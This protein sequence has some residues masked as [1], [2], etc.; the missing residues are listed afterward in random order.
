MLVEKKD[1]KELYA[2][3]SIRKK[4]IIE[5]DQIEHMKT[6]R[7]ILEYVLIFPFCNIYKQHPNKNRFNIHFLSV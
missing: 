6:E 2:L 1:T 4:D 5:K 3:K 7:R